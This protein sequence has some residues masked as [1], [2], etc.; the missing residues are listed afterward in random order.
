MLRSL[1]RRGN[2]QRVS[3]APVSFLAALV[4]CLVCLDM[5]STP[6]VVSAQTAPRQPRGIYAVY[7]DTG[8]RTC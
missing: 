3:F 8:L 4:P 5:P 1:R 7:L 6:V 2:V